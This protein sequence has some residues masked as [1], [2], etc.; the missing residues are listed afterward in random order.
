MSMLTLIRDVKAGDSILGKLYF[1]G[2]IVCYT[3]ENAAKAIPCCMY[4][5]Q[6]SKSPKFKRKL[7][8]IWNAKVPASRGIRIHV[9]NSVKDSSGCVL[10][11]MG[12][13]VHLLGGSKLKESA[14]AE[15]MVTML[16]R[17]VTEFIIT[18][19]YQ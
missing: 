19:E 15:A 4:S 16:C 9:G 3:L 17:N 2:G 5:V 6:N 10:V 8:L 18:E 1:N 14:S 12:R 11:G 13:D 7:P